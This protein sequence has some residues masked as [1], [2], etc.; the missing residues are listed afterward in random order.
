MST[1][2]RPSKVRFIIR[3]SYTSDGV[4]YTAD[5]YTIGRIHT[6]GHVVW[7]KRKNRNGKGIEVKKYR[8]RGGTGPVSDAAEGCAPHEIKVRCENND[9]VIVSRR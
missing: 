9:T 3:T 1:A 5:S 2:R 7:M 8:A 4:F 6:D